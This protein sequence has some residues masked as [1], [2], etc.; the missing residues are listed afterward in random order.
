MSWSFRAEIDAFWK[1]TVAWEV[2]T[3]VRIGLAL[4]LEPFRILT[5]A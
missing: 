5:N 3:F 4:V 2:K 1:H